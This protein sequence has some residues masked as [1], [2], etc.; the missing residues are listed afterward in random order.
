MTNLDLSSVFL[1]AGSHYDPDDGMCVMEA[2]SVAAG[3][4]FGDHPECASPV[5]AAWL[6]V[7]NDKLPDH[8][9]QQLKRYIPRL[10]RSAGTVDQERTRVLMFTDWYIRTYT[11]TWLHAAGLHNEAALGPKT[12]IE[13]QFLGGVAKYTLGWTAG[14]VSTQALKEWVFV[15]SH[16]SF[17]PLN[18]ALS[19][20]RSAIQLIVRR[21]I[22]RVPRPAGVPDQVWYSWQPV[23]VNEALWETCPPVPVWL[24]LYET[25]DELTASAF[26]LLDRMLAVT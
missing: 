16:V 18:W 4:P 21:A 15:D 25:V 20:S 22:Q 24:E 14:L 8:N 12:N 19:I 3:E 17:D 1:D 7:W 13:L 23:E 5:I 2:V 9:R 10:V 11:P 26:G 6:R